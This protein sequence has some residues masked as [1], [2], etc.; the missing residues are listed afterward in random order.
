MKKMSE[1]SD[2]TVSALRFD[3]KRCRIDWFGAVTYAARYERDSEPKIEMQL[4]L[5]PD[6]VT[7]YNSL[8]RFEPGTWPLTRQVLV[9]VSFLAFLKIGDIWCDGK[10]VET[11]QYEREDFSSLHV[12]REMSAL[13]KAG[14]S[15][16]D[17][18]FFLPSGYHPYH[19]A[20]TQSYCVRIETEDQFIVVPSSEL[21]RFYF[22]TTG[23]VISRLFEVPLN[24]EC[25]W[26]RLD[27]EADTGG[28][29]IDLATGLSGWAAPS[30]ARI[31]MSP[32]AR[33]AAE[34]VGNSCIAAIANGAKAYPKVVFPFEGKTDLVAA[35]KWLPFGDK[36]K[37]VFLVFRLES[38]SHPFPFKS[39]KFTSDAAGAAQHARR[40]AAAA[41]DV[42]QKPRV[43]KK[44][45]DP[46][47]VVDQEPS[48]TKATK[49][50]ELRSG[51]LVQFPD[52]SR[53]SVTKTD[54][55][56]IPKVVFS[57]E[58]ATLISGSSPGHS[59]SDRSIQPIDVVAVDGTAFDPTQKI[60]DP[61]LPG[62]AKAFLELFGELKTS[63]KFPSVEVVPLGTRQRYGFVSTMPTVTDE[64]GV[65]LDACLFSEPVE[66]KPDRYRNRKISVCRL[67]DAWHRH[68]VLI[69]EPRLIDSAEIYEAH[70]IGD[71]SK[72]IR[73]VDDLNAAIA[74]HLTRSSLQHADAIA[75]GVWSVSTVLPAMQEPHPEASGI[76][77]ALAQACLALLEMLAEHAIV[78]A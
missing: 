3:G 62:F 36:A 69:P 29:K 14:I 63:G 18:R 73:S 52:L 10:F 76:G 61:N 58:G 49:S 25:F 64:D 7:D 13:M 40:K 24:T 77:S 5:I 1:L 35:G 23:K 54:A 78:T 32:V 56:D 17:G 67:T 55:D 21:L 44:A 2:Y 22:G 45:D 30:V 68:Y 46:K 41:A 66:G 50:Y 33:S 39:L 9:P 51:R 4:S 70:L 15:D 19:M 20:Y 27:I 38:C 75:G 11:P 59:G 37:G 12:V 74:T 16:D 8:F 42:A 31:A 53:K 72:S 26:T 65:I 57:K 34:L 28:T 71:Y 43:I 47:V 60:A 6:N 48:R